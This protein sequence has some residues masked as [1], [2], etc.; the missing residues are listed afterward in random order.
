MAVRDDFAI[1]RHDAAAGQCCFEL[2][3]RVK[4]G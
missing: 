2:I 3:D 1:L 4:H